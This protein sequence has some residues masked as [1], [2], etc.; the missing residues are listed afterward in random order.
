MKLLCLCL[1]VWFSAVAQQAPQGPNVARWT[2]FETEFTSPKNYDN[3]LL[4]VR[5]DVAFTAPSGKEHPTEA[6]W[7]GERIWRV[8][9]SPDEI[10][11][12]TYR[13]IASDA[14]NAGLHGRSGSFN[15][16]AYTGSNPLYRHGALKTSKDGYTLEHADGTPFFWLADTCWAGPLLSDE[17]SW[18]KYL[19]DRTG[20]RFTTIQFM[21]TQNIAAAADAQGRQAFGGR[22]KIV[23]DPYF[24]RRLDKRIDAI[25]EAGLIASPTFLWAAEWHPS[26]KVLDPGAWL[27]DDQ[28]IA[29]GRYFTARYGAHQV[30]WMFAGDHDYRGDKA[31]RWR[32]LGRAVFG[33]SPHRLVTMHPAPRAVLQNEFAS[34]KWLGFLGYQSSHSSRDETVKWIVQGEP[35]TDWRKAPARPVINI[36]PI[37]EAHN[38]FGR[39]RVASALDVRQ[40]VWWSLL[41]SPTAGVSYGGHGVWS[42]E[43]Q[44]AIPM[45][46][47]QTRV[48]RPWH[49]A[50]NLP[51]SSHMRVA[52]DILD[53]VAWSQLRPAPALLAVQ[54]GASNVQQFVA[55]SRTLDS[56]AAVAYVPSEGVVVELVEAFVS[57]E[58]LD[59]TNGKA[60]PASASGREFKTP[61]KNAA[62][63]PDWVLLLRR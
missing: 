42:W 27:P 32:K 45:N 24:F 47:Y 6:F 63:D 52:R 14:A 44:P 34:E 23:I 19:V 51:G 53:R 2:R 59:P 5:V 40:A 15:V 41:V 3:D 18:K 20:K 22:E 8:R 37:Y 30:V 28:A 62:G 13:T 60:T 10:G 35:A 57:A 39:D 29:F 49:E 38:N 26:A 31:E 33:D 1:V 4:D 11:R 54:P 17:A 9:F 48:A 36:E 16:T 25:N 56:R 50:I 61:G 43:I 58:W 21:G 12:W 7:D 55:I 46:H